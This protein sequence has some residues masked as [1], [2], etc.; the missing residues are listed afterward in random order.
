MTIEIQTKVKTELKALLG[1]RKIIWFKGIKGRD[2]TDGHTNFYARFAKP[3]VVIVSRD[4]DPDSYDYQI[5][6]EN[7]DILK[8]AT[9]AD[10]NLLELS[11][12]DT[13]IEINEAF[14]TKDF[15]AG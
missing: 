6:Q 3:G 4:T 2:I 13:P 7:I 14:G 12:I 10:G 11:I 1:L 8:S 5:K 15:A 9:D